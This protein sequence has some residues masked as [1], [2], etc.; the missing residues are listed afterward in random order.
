MDKNIRGIEAYARFCVSERGSAW[1]LH[2]WALEATGRGR[3]T[4]RLPQRQLV[5]P[6]SECDPSVAF[7][8]V[9]RCFCARSNGKQTRLHGRDLH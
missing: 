4:S 3:A 7:V 2:L 8:L 9:S 6:N 5:E 1:C